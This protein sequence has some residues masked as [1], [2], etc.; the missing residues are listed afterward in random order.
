MDIVHVTEKNEF[1]RHGCTNLNTVAFSSVYLF[2]E[3]LII[4]Y[5]VLTLNY[6]SNLNLH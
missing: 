5:K 1:G 6:G 4:L 3:V 2:V